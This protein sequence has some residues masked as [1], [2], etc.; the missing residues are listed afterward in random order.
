M[1]PIIAITTGDLCGIG[2]EV[3]VKALSDDMLHTVCRPFVIGSAGWIS[4][5]AA[6]FAPALSIRPIQALSEA[7]FDAGVLDILDDPHPM[8][9][10]GLSYG[11]PDLR[12][13]A[14]AF[15]ALTRATDMALA[16]EVDGITTAPIHKAQMKQVGFPAP[17]HTEFLADRAGVKSFGMMM[18]GGG[19][20]ITLAT[21]HLAL[22]EAARIRMAEILSAIRLTHQAMSRD[23]GMKDAKIAVAALNPHGGEEGLFGDEEQREVAP[24]VQ[25]A[26]EEGIGASGPYPAD[27]LFFHL[28]RGRFDA[29]VAL[30]HDQALIPIKLLAFGDAVNVTL[31]LP[32]VRTSVDHGT[33]HDIAGR[34]IADA[35]SLK[36]AVLLAAQM[37]G[38]RKLARNDVEGG[39]RAG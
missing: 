29:A 16:G 4:H 30:Y 14:A 9:L 5:A 6:R 10:T 15:S 27:T 28:K 8:D 3:I 17:G 38:H 21:I 12:A 20:K 37:A 26:Q 24:A 23:F 1:K 34:G 39:T 2:P 11:Q 32:F 7:H 19:L 35:G 36:T 25:A 31:G 18:V 22:R 13:A 33:A